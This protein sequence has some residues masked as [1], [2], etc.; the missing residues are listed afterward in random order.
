MPDQQHLPEE[1]AQALLRERTPLA[2]DFCHGPE[3]MLPGV[4]GVTLGRQWRRIQ[5]KLPEDWVHARL[6]LTVTTPQQLDHAA[7]LLAPLTPGR[8]GNR[9]R[10]EVIRR[11]HAHSPAAVG[12][13]LG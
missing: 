1:I 10:F 5:A 12:R 9:L 4:N 6:A 7:S 11:G 13:A 2:L 3:S 8:A